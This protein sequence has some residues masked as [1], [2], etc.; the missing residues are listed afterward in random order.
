M[1]LMGN[2]VPTTSRR[3]LGILVCLGGGLC[4]AD[5]NPVW[6]SPVPVGPVP[7]GLVPVGPVPVGLVP[8]GPVPVGPVPVGRA[9]HNE[10][11]RMCPNFRIFNFFKDFKFFSGSGRVPAAPGTS[12]YP[13]SILGY[14]FF[15]KKSIFQK[16]KIS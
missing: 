14:R 9:S 11:N 4:S 15:I 7:V 2:Y 3:V 16:S 8:V 13:Y 12:C 6:S 5:V 10:I 1:D